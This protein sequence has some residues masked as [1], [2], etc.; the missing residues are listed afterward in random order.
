[1]QI[2]CCLS[3]I[4]KNKKKHFDSCSFIFPNKAIS[5]VSK[6]YMTHKFETMKN[7]KSK[8]NKNQN[9]N[10]WL[11]WWFLKYFNIFYPCYTTTS[12]YV[13][14]SFQKDIISRRSFRFA[15]IIMLF[16]HHDQFNSVRSES[17]KILYVAIKF[18][19][20]WKKLNAYER[21]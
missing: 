3:K 14:I 21:Q 13:T 11:K 16:F 18:V 8:I 5:Y 9:S 15:N 20:N 17:I 19:V 10:N 1:M 7:W 12:H 2:V 4:F 6:L